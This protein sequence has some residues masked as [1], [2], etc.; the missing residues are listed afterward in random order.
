MVVTFVPSLDAM[1]H[2]GSIV[3]SKREA[4][5]ATMSSNGP[6][7]YEVLKGEAIEGPLRTTRTLGSLVYIFSPWIG[8]VR[9]ITGGMGVLV[10]VSGLE[11]L[12]ALSLGVVD[13]LGKGNERG[14]R[15]RSI[16]SRHF[17]VEDRLMV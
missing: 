16:G 9:I 4:F 8:P 1:P 7:L 10:I 3:R 6:S 12:E 15:S 5:Q 2:L 14:R 11:P 13:I 17:D